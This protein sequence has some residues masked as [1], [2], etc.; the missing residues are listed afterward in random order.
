MPDELL[1]FLGAFVVMLLV[2]LARGDLAGLPTTLVAAGVIFGVAT[3]GI[4]AVLVYRSLSSLDEEYL[5]AIKIL[6]AMK[7]YAR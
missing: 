6:E 5:V 7:D 1:A 2:A 3:P 4:A